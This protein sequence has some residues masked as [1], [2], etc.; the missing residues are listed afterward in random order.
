MQEYVYIEAEKEAHVRDAI[1]G[2]RTM[3]IS[4]GVRLVPLSEMVHAVTVNKTAKATICACV[5]ACVCLCVR[6]S[7][8]LPRWC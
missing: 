7:V 4:K 1:R 3:F 5:C 2:L 8:H 6:N